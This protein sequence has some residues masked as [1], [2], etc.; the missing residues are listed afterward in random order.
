MEH[1]RQWPSDDT[2][3]ILWPISLQDTM[4][5]TKEFEACDAVGDKSETNLSSLQVFTGV[6]VIPELVNGWGSGSWGSGSGEG[7]GNGS[8]GSG[9]EVKPCS[10]FS[11][12]FHLLYALICALLCNHSLRNFIWTF[13]LMSETLTGT[14]RSVSEL[15]S[16]FSSGSGDTGTRNKDLHGGFLVS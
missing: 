1:I 16:L 10:M 9:D 5:T 2:F 8:G 14:W 15:S 3:S 7:S 13:L 12:S 4:G 11:S 6:L